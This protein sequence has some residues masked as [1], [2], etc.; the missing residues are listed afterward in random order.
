M[1]LTLDQRKIGTPDLPHYCSLTQLAVWILRPPF[2]QMILWLNLKP[3]VW[4]V[5]WLTGHHLITKWT[6]HIN[7]SL[8][9]QRQMTN[10]IKAFLFAFDKGS[11]FLQFASISWWPTFWQNPEKLTR[12]SIWL[13]PV[14][15]C[16]RTF[17]AAQCTHNSPKSFSKLL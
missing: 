9:V 8:P 11:V 4:T 7:L 5:C 3:K 6:Q 14:T 2:C 17:S 1:L 10:F 16:T 15:W 13:I 12:F